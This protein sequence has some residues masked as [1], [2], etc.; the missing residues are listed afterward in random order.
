MMTYLLNHI[1]F[2]TA[3]VIYSVSLSSLTS[4]FIFS[5]KFKRPADQ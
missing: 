4:R 2:T 5:G 1:D 3:R